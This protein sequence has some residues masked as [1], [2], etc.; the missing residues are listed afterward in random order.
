[1]LNEVLKC[2]T[3]SDKRTDGCIN[4]INY[5]KKYLQNWKYDVKT[6]FIFHL[7]LV[8]IPSSLISFVK[9]IGWGLGIYLADKI[10]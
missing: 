10:C 9:N 7:M 2:K 3:I 5:Y 8:D 6:T 4:L 1:M